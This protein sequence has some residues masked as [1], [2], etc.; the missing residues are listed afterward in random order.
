MLQEGEHHLFLEVGTQVPFPTREDLEKIAWPSLTLPL[1]RCQRTEA[2]TEG[3]VRLQNLM[4]TPPQGS[5]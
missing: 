1:W 3:H 4:C 5:P 2:E